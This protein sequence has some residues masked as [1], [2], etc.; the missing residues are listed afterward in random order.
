MEEEYS[1]NY[2]TTEWILDHIAELFDYLFG[3]HLLPAILFL[4]TTDMCDKLAIKLTEEMR[5]RN[6]QTRFQ[7]NCYTLN[8]EISEHKRRS[9]MKVPEI[10]F[11]AW[12]Y[13][14]GVHHANYHTK[15]RSSVEYLFRLRELQI[16]F[17]P[18]RLF[19]VV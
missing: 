14:N 13:C 18:P 1:T 17:A 9:Y 11:E 6:E 3:K 16:V 2:A 7:A 4:K 15:Y 10:M 5:K 19:Y 8:E 12:Q